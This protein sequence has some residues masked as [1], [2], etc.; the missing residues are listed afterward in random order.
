MP[1]GVGEGAQL[2]V[3][4]HDVAGEVLAP[5]PAVGVAAL[6]AGRYATP[7][8]A[9]PTRC[10]PTSPC[11]RFRQPQAQW[12]LL[13]C[14]G[15]LVLVAV[16]P[17]GSGAARAQSSDEVAPS[18]EDDLPIPGVPRDGVPNVLV[19]FRDLATGW[20]FALHRLGDQLSFRVRNNGKAI[21]NAYAGPVI[22]TIRAFASLWSDLEPDIAEI[23]A[24]A[25]AGSGTWT[26]D[27]DD[28]DALVRSVG[29]D[30]TEGFVEVTGT[31]ALVAETVYLFRTD[32]WEYAVRSS[33]GR[34]ANVPD[35]LDEYR[36]SAV[37]AVSPDGQQYRYEGTPLQSGERPAA[38]CRP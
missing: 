36:S 10:V 2:R 21:G 19:C 17:A 33:E 37:I 12:R 4:R 8:P 9:S 27:I 5:D 29:A 38:A 20:N 14:W 3:R 32:G 15:I 11:G 18:H 31:T 16:I 1:V 26:L 28:Q 6:G 23:A 24:R 7:P 34:P 30:R 22:A 35:D 13:V 25:E